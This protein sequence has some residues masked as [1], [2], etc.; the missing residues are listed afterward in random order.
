VQSTLTLPPEPDSVAEARRHV[1]EL[2]AYELE[3]D[4]LAE[5]ELVV[6]E[7]VT[8][9][10]RHGPGNQPLTLR[11]ALDDAGRLLG[12]VEDKGDGT[13]EIRKQDP[14]TIVGGLGLPI[15]EQVTTDWGVYPGSTHVWFRFDP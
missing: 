7:L 4:R 5:V 14:G 1:R 12:E 3:P 13:I 6:S 2:L 8:N 11:L 10:V 9:A 15:V